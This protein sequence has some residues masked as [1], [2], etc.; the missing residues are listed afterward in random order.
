MKNISLL[1]A[2][3]ILGACSGGSNPN[4]N[5]LYDF[6]RSTFNPQHTCAVPLNDK[7]LAIGTTIRGQTDI[8]HVSLTTVDPFTGLPVTNS[9]EYRGNSYSTIA[10]DL[11]QSLANPEHVVAVG[12][13][14]PYSQPNIGIVVFETDP[15][16]GVVNWTTHFGD[17]NNN[18]RA[19]AII[20][21]EKDQ[22][23]YLL[24]EYDYAENEQGFREMYLC[25]FDKSGIPRW[26][27]HYRDPIN[28][29]NFI[30]GD[31][32]YNTE[33][34]MLIITSKIV[35]A[36]NMLGVVV[37]NI[38][39]NNGNVLSTSRITQIGGNPDLR[40]NDAI[41]AN[42]RAVLVG[43]LNEEP[44]R[45]FLLIFEPGKTSTGLISKVYSADK[46][47]IRFSGIRQQAK[48]LLYASFD[49]QEGSSQPNPGLLE[50][51]KEGDIKSSFIYEVPDYKASIGLLTTAD[52]SRLI[53]K[54]TTGFNDDHALLSLVSVGSPLKDDQSICSGK[55]G[56]S[57]SKGA[58]VEDY[59]LKA[60][61]LKTSYETQMEVTDGKAEVRGCRQ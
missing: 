14:P 31:L 1:F 6:E 53:V 58:E 11:V 2:I 7:T 54:G 37:A 23:Y 25:A 15:K 21:N 12:S 20:R 46:Q 48:G 16:T 42:G 36:G 52:Q 57:M 26:E 8:R 49:H 39:P 38:N 43:E 56:I 40:I 22:I 61:E 24:G 30:S 34:N 29:A 9:N 5:N 4:Y 19:K 47:S 32:L 45:S 18:F 50:M 55:V 41:N 3:A 44:K 27:M 28:E 51:E 10:D 17:P 33:N 35:K 59:E 13:Y 60:I